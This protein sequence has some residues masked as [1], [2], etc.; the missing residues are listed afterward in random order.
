MELV[1][2][3]RAGHASAFGELARRL[4][5]R[6]TAWGLRFS[7]DADEAED[8]AQL[9]LLRLHDHVDA[10]E[11]RSRLTSWLYR[12]TRNLAFDRRRRARHR[13]ALLEAEARPEHA[14]SA[15]HPS[16]SLD[17]RALARLINAYS[18]DLSARQR[19]VFGLVDLEGRTIAEVAERLGVEQVTV[20]VLLSRARRTI[21]L[22]ILEEHPRLLAEYQG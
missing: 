14:E 17:A 3:T 5:S 9:V 8:I 19:E 20:R 18:A 7:G 1:A 2:R 6:L 10:F 13:A 21:R 4:R 11:G 15:S 16:D 12:I 22:R